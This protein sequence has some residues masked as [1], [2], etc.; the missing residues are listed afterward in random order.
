MIQNE[1]TEPEPRA[2][3]KNQQ[4]DGFRRYSVSN[5]LSEYLHYPSL[6]VSYCLHE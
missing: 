5:H 2:T 6:I 3:L 1:T 4:A